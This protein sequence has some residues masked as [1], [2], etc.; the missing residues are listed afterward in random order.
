MEADV[1]Y[2]EQRKATELMLSERAASP[3]AASAHRALALIYA[4]EVRRLSTAS[5]RRPVAH[6][7][8][9]RG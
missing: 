1:Q 5:I 3:E 8:S 4:E 6:A 9:L 2:Y 7:A